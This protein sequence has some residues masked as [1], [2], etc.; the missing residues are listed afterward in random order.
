VR[1]SAAEIDQVLGVPAGIRV[2]ISLTTLNDT[3]PRTFADGALA[4][5]LAGTWRDMDWDLYQY[6]GA[7]TGPDADLTASLKVARTYVDARGVTHLVAP[8]DVHLVQAHDTMHMTGADWSAVLGGATVRAEVAWFVNR[9]FLTITSDLISPAALSALSAAERTRIRTRL[10]AGERAA[11]PLG[12]L[13]PDRNAVQWGVGADYLVHGFLPLLQ[14]TQLWFTDSGPPQLYSDPET[15]VIASVRRNFWQETLE[16]EMRSLVE[17][18][19]GAW[20]LGPRA[21]YRAGDHW[22][23]RFGYLAIDGPLDSTVGQYHHN[24]EFVLEARYLF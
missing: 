24:D 21:T 5:R 16:L 9:P 10:A 1:F 11:I 23:F 12:E 8:A 19:R 4:F 18:E 22:R 7:N 6:S 14:V 15:Q 2:P 20:M 17:V 13:F 3:P